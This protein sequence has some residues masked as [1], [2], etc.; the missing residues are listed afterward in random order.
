MHSP[1]AKYVTYQ[2]TYRFME[3]IRSLR[4][5][6]VCHYIPSLVVALLSR[7][8][9][10]CDIVQLS[11]NNVFPTSLTLCMELVRASD[12]HYARMQKKHAATISNEDNASSSKPGQHSLIYGDSSLDLIEQLVLDTLWICGEGVA[13]VGRL[14]M[15]GKVH[16][17]V[18]LESLITNF[19]LPYI[20]ISCIIYS[21]AF[22]TVYICVC[23]A[24]RWAC[25]QCLEEERKM[26][27]TTSQP[28]ACNTNQQG[29]DFQPINFYWQQ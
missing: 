8:G 19:I 12:I 28:R 24:Y 23:D 15:R 27:F 22:D 2:H 13:V 17:A 6:L 29:V 1:L 25:V 14:L 5:P 26:C 21:L 10:V 11:Q 9:Q 3:V 18:C 20:Y 16:Q 7:C 4:I